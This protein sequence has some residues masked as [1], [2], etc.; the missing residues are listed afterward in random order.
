M[1]HLG[2]G[3]LGGQPY[4]VRGGCGGGDHTMS[5]EKGLPT[6]EH[7]WQYYGPMGPPWPWALSSFAAKQFNCLR[8]CLNQG[9]LLNLCLRQLNKVDPC[10]VPPF[11]AGLYL[12]AAIKFNR[13]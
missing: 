7:I 6:L 12:D 2:P 1:A 11:A 9:P 5:A 13:T 3:P 4:P 10:G 8:F